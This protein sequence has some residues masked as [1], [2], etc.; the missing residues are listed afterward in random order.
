MAVLLPPAPLPG[1]GAATGAA[2]DAGTGAGEAPPPPLLLNPPPPLTPSPRRGA[3]GGGGIGT[4]GGGEPA[5]ALAGLT[6]RGGGPDDGLGAEEATASG[7]TAGE[8]TP[9]ADEA[10]CCCCWACAA[11]RSDLPRRFDWVAPWFE[12]SCSPLS[13]SCPARFRFL[14]EAAMSSSTTSM[15]SSSPD[16]GGS[17]RSITLIIIYTSLSVAGTFNRHEVPSRCHGLRGDLRAER[18]F[19]SS[20]SHMTTIQVS[21]QSVQYNVREVRSRNTSLRSVP[22]LRPDP[23]WV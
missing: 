4:V 12:P 22:I 6:S 8:E 3:G 2:G 16:P 11:A 7:E 5:A 21:Y 20:T 18:G 19:Q 15:A 23:L 14:D 10:D 13:T 1:L 9:P 17:E